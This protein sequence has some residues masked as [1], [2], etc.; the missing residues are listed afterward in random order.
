MNT[1]SLKT[2]AQNARNKLRA[3]VAARLNY[4][5][6]A[7]GGTAP[8]TAAHRQF[9]PQIKEL[10][11]ALKKEGRDALVERISYTWFNRLAALR[12]MDA[13][14]FHPFGVR[15]VT[16]AGENE[17]LPALLQ[18]ARAGA[19]NPE[20][21]AK[22]ANPQAFDDILAGRI[23][24]A[25]PETELFGMLLLAACNYYHAMMPFLFEKLGD[26][27]QL[28]LPEDLLSEQS[29]LTDIR[30]NLTDEDCTEVELIGWLYQFYISE[31]KDEVMGRKKAVPTED[32]PA[33]TQLF[34]PHWIVRYL[35]ENSLGRLWLLNRPHSRLREQMPYYIDGEPETDFLKIAKPE[36]IKLVD[37]ACGSGHMLTYAFDLLYLIYE[38]EGYD[39]PEIPSLILKHNL[40]GLEICDRA[41]ALAAFALCMKARAKDRRFFKRLTEGGDQAPRPHI[42]EL[43]DVR[44]AENELRDYIHALKLGNIFQHT[45]LKLLHQFE[46]AKNFGSLIQPCETEAAIF[47]IRRIVSDRWSEITDHSPSLFLREIH[48]NVLRVLEQAEALTQRYH[49]VVANPP[50]MGSRGMNSALKSFAETSFTSTRTDLFAMFITRSFEFLIPKGWSSMVTMQSWMFLPSYLDFRK[51]ILANHKICCMAHL[52]PHAF[53][54]IGGEIVQ[55]TATI[56]NKITSLTSKGAYISLV[57]GK[58]EKDKNEELLRK[59][60]LHYMSAEEFLSLPASPIAYWMSPRTREIFR[61]GERL[62][63]IA[64]PRQG[65]A[66]GNND[67][68][69]RYWH[70]TSHEKIAF[71]A[72]SADELFKSTQRWVPYSKGGPARK[73]YGNGEYVISFD[74][75]S[76][77]ILAKSGNCLPSRHLYFKEALNW[78]LTSS[79]GFAARF[80]PAGYVF[81]VN[82]M[83]SFTD[84]GFSRLLGLVNSS[85]GWHLLR[86]I[87]PTMA[88]Q[89]GDIKAFPCINVDTTHCDSQVEGAIALARS[90]WDNFETSWDFRDQ[91]LLRSAGKGATLE[92]SWRHWEEQS[93]SAIRRMQELETENNRLFIAAYGLD[94]E[95]QPEVSEEQ[96]T[97]TRADVRC[98]IA[99]FISYAVGCMMGRYSLDQSGLI[100]ANAGATVEEYRAKVPN[101][102]FAPDED[103]ILPVLDDEWFSDDIVGRFREFLRV[104]FGEESFVAN[105]R[106]IEE[107][108]GKP[109]A[110]TGKIKPTEIRSY[111][112][113]D[114]YKNHISTER[115]Y[116]YKKR[117]I[118]WMVSSP[119]GSF[120]ALIY[121]HRYTRDTL[122]RVLDG[123]VRP[124]LDKLEQRQQACTVISNDAAAKPAAR[125]AAAKELLKLGKMLKEIREWERDTLLPL[126]QK[127]IELDL[128]DGVKVNYLK[129]K[130]ILVPIAGLE[131]KEED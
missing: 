42:I 102:T 51:N 116:G 17:I 47:E 114:F 115:A 100:L 108:L 65:L 29:I 1:S 3:Q 16:P 118:Y 81:D 53:D 123:Y 50:Y 88:F 93:A 68:F 62:E 91:P 77:D 122:N 4:W 30:E 111:F 125:T 106:F 87:N 105:L 15:V 57:E 54:S 121:L 55:T 97:L 11:E 126:A 67:V 38:E 64:S 59:A 66:T 107:S 9:A 104:T 69:L 56:I 124:F 46:E 36:D 131:K 8:D 34:T 89:V 58:S 72:E 78:S 45:I 6:G 44:F 40:H 120:Q 35:V 73:W 61:T 43:Q 112:V 129:F 18:Q 41:A 94:G 39:A 10:A 13:N 26:A 83:S 82:G 23:P 74:K 117:P 2:F 79:S 110:K 32:I 27:T 24:V 49:V 14:D 48:H 90:D 37:P 109:E 119:N 12:F 20:I 70:E 103:G 92:S 28:L 99:A 113:S 101:S 80:R 127:R 95:L 63:N 128:D 85:I 7:E 19:L 31:K 33:V 96:I 75:K 21:R 71:S 22:L 5:L 76:Y 84:G 25:H 130:G 86:I 98:D 60:H 52:G